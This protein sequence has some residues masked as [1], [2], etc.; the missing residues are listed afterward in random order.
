MTVSAMDVWSHSGSYLNYL[1]ALSIQYPTTFYIWISYF[2]QCLPILTKF[3]IITPTLGVI[4]T[5]HIL[6]KVFI[7]CI[8]NFT[9]LVTVRFSSLHS[10]C[11]GP[12]YFACVMQYIQ[13]CII[14]HRTIPVWHVSHLPV[15]FCK[16]FPL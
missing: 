10:S 13:G 1:K 3:C 9:W 7:V 6:S 8:F 5:I 4:F 14:T 12:T 16:S 15:H 11:P 2:N